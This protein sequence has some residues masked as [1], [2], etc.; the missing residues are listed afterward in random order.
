[1]VLKKVYLLLVY[2]LL[3][4]TWKAYLEKKDLLILKAFI[5]KKYYIFLICT[6]FVINII[7]YKNHFRNVA[8]F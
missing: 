3:K 6:L 4:A 7:L 5:Y 2:L 8:K 1:M